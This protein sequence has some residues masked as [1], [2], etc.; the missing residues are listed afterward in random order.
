MDHK[1]EHRTPPTS[2]GNG[3]GLTTTENLSRKA[4]SCHPQKMSCP[5]E[6]LPDEEVF[7]R[8]ESCPL[9]NVYVSHFV[10]PSDLH[11]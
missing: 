10:L 3:S 1:R 11:D 9:E 6:I 2:K 5:V 7:H 4:A 8:R